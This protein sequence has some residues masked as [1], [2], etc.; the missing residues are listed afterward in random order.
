MPADRAIFQDD[1]GR[2]WLVEIQYGHPA[3]VERGIFAA[4][5]VCPEDAREPVRLG[6]LY[7]AALD[8]GDE[9]ALREALEESEPARSIG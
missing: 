1:Q 2:G 5:F 9:S 8:A 6:Y 4:R 3:P 7:R